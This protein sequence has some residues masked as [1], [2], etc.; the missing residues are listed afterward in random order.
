[1]K[2]KHLRN[3]TALAV[4]L[5]MTLQMLP[6]ASFAQER[7][8]DCEANPEACEQPAPPAEK[9]PTRERQAG[10]GGAPPAAEQAPEAAVPDK[11]PA[12]KP[13]PPRSPPKSLKRCNRRRSK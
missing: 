8:V 11:E 1:M 5:A 3:S 7:E 9:N 4:V 6:N 12:R 10:R 2:T 13:V